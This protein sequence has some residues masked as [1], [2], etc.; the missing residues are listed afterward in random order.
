MYVFVAQSLMFTNLTLNID[1]MDYTMLRQMSRLGRLLARK[2]DKDSKNEPEAIHALDSIL[3]PEKDKFEKHK[4]LSE[5]KLAKFLAQKKREMPLPMYNLILAYLASIGEHKLNFWGTRNA[6]GVTTLPDP[7]H[8]SLILPPRAKRC[9]KCYVEKRMYSC[10]SSHQGNSLIQFYTPGTGRNQNETFTGVIDAILKIPL[11]NALR[12]FILVRK[13]QPLS[14]PIYAAHPE[15]MATV[16]YVEPQP[17]QVV[18]EPKNLSTHLT[19]WKRGSE[20][21]NTDKPVMVV[22]WAL[23]RGRR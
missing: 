18:I 3:N 16:V 6:A 2:H 8:R 10:Y 9:Q 19:A 5:A 1:D 20:T 21:Y 7:D 12:T 17:G 23:N 4:G 11:D 22:C 15:L 13:H 14:I